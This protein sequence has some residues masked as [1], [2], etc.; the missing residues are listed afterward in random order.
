MTETRV[1]HLFY[2]FYLTSLG[3]EKLAQQLSFKSFKKFRKKAKKGNEDL[4]QKAFFLIIQI[5]KK[6]WHQH[7]SKISGSFFSKIKNWTLK[8]HPKTWSYFRNR[9]TEEEFLALI[10][11][12][13]LQVPESQMAK[14][15]SIPESR[16]YYRV[17]RALRLLASEIVKEKRTI[18]QVKH[19]FQATAHF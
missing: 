12:K 2:L 5:T 9:T 18:K 11:S 10:W 7:K 4:S 3:D 19:T 17:G 13:V 16:V 14:A 8:P 6:F 15:L 1:I